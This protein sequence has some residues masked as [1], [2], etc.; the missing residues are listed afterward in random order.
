MQ[1]CVYL[2]PIYYV[3]LSLRDVEFCIV[4]V[5][6]LLVQLIYC[7]LYFIKSHSMRPFVLQAKRK[8]PTISTFLRLC[9]YVCI[10]MFIYYIV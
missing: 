7:Y 8:I 9:I 5:L 3:E 4:V 1:A 6:E 10:Y 2:Q